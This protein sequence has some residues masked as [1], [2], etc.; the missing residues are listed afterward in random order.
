[1]RENECRKCVFGKVDLSIKPCI[2]GTRKG[3]IIM[4]YHELIKKIRKV[5]K[6]RK[7][8]TKEL[9]EINKRIANILEKSRKGE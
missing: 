2:D 8:L 1:M 6:R 4:N 3:G 7:Q 9:M 5:E